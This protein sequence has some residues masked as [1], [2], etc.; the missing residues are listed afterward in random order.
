MNRVPLWSKTWWAGRPVARK[1]SRVP[2]A[3]APDSWLPG[4]QWTGM[5]GGTF[6]FRICSASAKSAGAELSTKSP[7][8]TMKSGLA[9]TAC[10]SADAACSAAN[11]DGPAAPLTCRSDMTAKRQRPGARL[12][13]A[14]T[15]GSGA[16]SVSTGTSCP[17]SAVSASNLS[18]PASLARLEVSTT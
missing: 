17:T 12:S 5:P 2:V 13:W 10:L 3:V 14:R 1:A 18:S 11:E 15:N 9:A 7:F 6:S 16:T 4:V 8:I